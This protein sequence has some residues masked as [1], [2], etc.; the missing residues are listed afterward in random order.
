[1]SRICKSFN[2]TLYFITLLLNVKRNI[3]GKLGKIL[4]RLEDPAVFYNDAEVSAV[5]I[6]WSID[7]PTCFSMRFWRA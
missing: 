1:M 6:R 4:R 5:V 7:M 3:I 2:I